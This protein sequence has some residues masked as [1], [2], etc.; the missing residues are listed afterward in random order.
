MSNVS[1]SSSAVARHSESDKMNVDKLSTFRAMFASLSEEERNSVLFTRT[2]I[3]ADSADYSFCGYA[4]S[5]RKDKN[6]A[7][8]DKTFTTSSVTFKQTD[9]SGNVRTSV[10]QSGG[11]DFKTCEANMY[12]QL[13]NNVR[14]IMNERET[15]RTS[16]NADVIIAAERARADELQ[17]KLEALQAQLAAK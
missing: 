13:R 17:A 4:F 11:K 2:R 12:A 6:A 3:D 16:T 9:K 10:A 1:Q 8:V 7:D 15:N 5:I 14:W